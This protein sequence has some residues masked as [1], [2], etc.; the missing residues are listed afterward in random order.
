MLLDVAVFAHTAV[1]ASTASHEVEE[2]Y[3]V[4]LLELNLFV[5]LFLSEIF[6]H[7]DGYHF[8]LEHLVDLD[9]FCQCQRKCYLLLFVVYNNLCHNRIVL[10]YVVLF[11]VDILAECAV[12][13]FLSQFVL[14]MMKHLFC[15][16]FFDDLSQIH[17][18]DMVGDAECLAEGVGYHYDAVILLQFSEELLHFLAGDR[19]ECRSTLV[20]KEIAWLYGKTAGEAEALLLT[21]TQLGSRTLQSILHFIPETY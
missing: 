10:F 5:V 1:L 14:R 18:D 8:R 19:I 15:A 13:I 9:E 2:I 11:Y 6:V 20:G 21:A 17:E 3:T 7:L 12:E 16:T 4:A